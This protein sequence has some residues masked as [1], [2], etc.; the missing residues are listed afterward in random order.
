[1][2]LAHSRTAYAAAAALLAIAAVAAVATALGS[3]RRAAAA[4]ALRQLGDDIIG[5]PN[6]GACRARTSATRVALGDSDLGAGL[7][8]SGR[9]G[10]RE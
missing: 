5:F 8:C 6:N 1:M 7:G 2:L 3:G 10:G 4:L 9:G